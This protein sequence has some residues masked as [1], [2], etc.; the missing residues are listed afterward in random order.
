M[1]GH[2]LQ[3]YDWCM[4]HSAHVTVIMYVKAYLRFHPFIIYTLLN[5]SVLGLCLRIYD[6]FG[7]LYDSLF[8]WISLTA[9]SR[10]YCIVW[11]N[12]NV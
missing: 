9:L 4:L 6:W 12:D 10:I 3:L 2:C 8:A 11:M 5:L 1:L 7:C